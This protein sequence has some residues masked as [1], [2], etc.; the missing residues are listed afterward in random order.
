ML[1]VID[2]RYT[3]YRWIEKSSN[4]ISSSF[5]HFLVQRI[6]DTWFPD[7]KTTTS[8]P[9]ERTNEIEDEKSLDFNDYINESSELDSLES[10]E[11][12]N[13]EN[14]QKFKAKFGRWKNVQS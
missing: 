2:L 10:D 7:L 11:S 9:V 3:G 1:D 6:L 13:E 12:S 4:V 8:A 14:L 5:P